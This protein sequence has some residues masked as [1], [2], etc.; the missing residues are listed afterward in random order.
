[1]LEK[2]IQYLQGCPSLTGKTILPD[3]LSDEVGSVSVQV[4]SCDPVIKSYADGATL[5]QFVFAIFVREGLHET[6]AQK[7]ITFF[8]EVETWLIG[9][10]PLLKDGQSAVKFEVIKSGALEERDY[11][12]RHYGMTGRLIYYQKGE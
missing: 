11:H 12:G 5:R 8:E 6:E 9:G 10:V 4:M 7:V 1:M 3:F 2:I